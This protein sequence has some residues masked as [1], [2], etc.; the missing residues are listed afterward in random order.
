MF[1]RTSANDCFWKLAIFR[2]FIGLG[3]QESSFFEG[4]QLNLKG[5]TISTKA[6]MLV[7]QKLLCVFEHE[8]T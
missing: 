2:S 6:L 1:E 7:L 4:K 8:D 3:L 5:N